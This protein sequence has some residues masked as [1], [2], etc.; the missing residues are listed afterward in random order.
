MSDRHDHGVAAVPADGHR[1]RTLPPM[2]TRSTERSVKAGA[3]IPTVLLLTI[4]LALCY[5]LLPTPK[6]SAEP[7]AGR[8][9][10]AATDQVKDNNQAKLAIRSSTP[11]V[12]A[13]SGYTVT[14]AVTNTSN[15]SL[16][17][18]R[19][20]ASTNNLYTF[21]SRIDMQ[22]WA[23]GGSRIPTPNLLAEQSVGAI[24]PGQSLEV[25]L[26]APAD[27]DQL[28]AMT[29]W[30]AKPVLLAYRSGPGTDTGNGKPQAS[31]GT[32]LTRSPDGLATAQTPALEVSMVLPLTTTGWTVDHSALHHL[33]TGERTDKKNAGNA[34]ANGGDKGRNNDPAQSS[35]PSRTT[36]T[37]DDSQT[38]PDPDASQSLVL[39]D[40][41]QKQ[42]KDQSQLLNRHPQLGT[43]A[44]PTYL[45]T[46][47]TMPRVDAGM[48]PS[49]FDMSSYAVQEEARYASA[50]VKP[51]D[52]SADKAGS[53][54]RRAM[55]QTDRTP[56]IYAWQ[57]KRPWSMD[58]LTQARRQ[59]YG[60]VVAPEGMDI[61]AGSSAHTGKYTVPTEAGN[62]TILSGQQ[63]LSNLAQGQPTSTKA[64]GEQTPAGQTARFMAQSAFYQMEQPYAERVLLVCF[65]T[66]QDTTA[67]DALM[68]AVEHA[69]WLKLSGLGSLDQAEPYQ[70]GEAAKAAVNQSGPSDGQHKESGLSGSL[71]S[72]TASRQDIARFSEAI[73]ASPSQTRSTPSAS[74]KS[75]AQALARQDADLA[76]HR[77]DDPRS[78][79]SEV[80]G[81]HDSLA[82]HTL[83]CTDKAGG[84][85]DT[86]RALADQLLNGI[87]IKPSESVTVVSETATMPVTVSNTLPY[88]V[89]ARVSAKTDSMEIVTTRTADT[90]IPAHSEAQVTFTVRVATAGQADA[91]ISLV[92]RQ[93]RPFS[94]TRTTR[95]NSHLRLSDM[96][97]LVIVAA[98]LLFGALGLW[99]QFHRTKD[100]DE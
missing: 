57:G 19:L 86:A 97:G 33:M 29:T 48:Q 64:A 68:T 62:I 75:D 49:A 43:V 72:L 9:V 25:T 79:L 71:D 90:V 12:S 35:A 17:P 60:T 80:T 47:G 95:I 65:G 44:E 82:L 26:S 52:W 100:P 13:S 81:L 73:L 15:G 67:A 7:M 99:R 59:G 14:L 94:Q 18:G 39:S 5:I 88:P 46:F 63:E 77:S 32:F 70:S 61:N 42:Q 4:L 84:L 53:Q 2:Q 51:A 3:R 83:A 28:K 98:A 78:W 30:G 37:T 31:V 96:S 40:R 1:H 91:E 92:D 27:N 38:T 50:G 16:A 45:G 93:G 10:Q 6:A 21:N 69:P 55:G 8:N 76:A 20:T 66:N 56:P 11:V 54:L 89:S 36:G 58:S 87:Q 24:Q 23:E 22:T 74:G 85:A 34:A 41:A